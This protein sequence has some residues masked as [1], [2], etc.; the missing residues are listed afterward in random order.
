MYCY[1]CGKEMTGDDKFCKSCGAVAGEEQKNDSLKWVGYTWTVIVNLVTLGVVVGI[2]NSIYNSFEIIT[3]SILIIIYLSIQTFAMTYGNA[4]IE[5]L[6]STHAEFERIRKI[7]NKNNEN[8]DD[9]ELEKEELKE[10]REK[11]N[12]AKIKMYINS[13]FIFILYI[14][15]VWHIFGSL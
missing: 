3:V 14:I 6:F 1:K 9:E 13:A 8:E 12:K 2:Y 4:T 5:S 11:V 10:A 15:A 7:L